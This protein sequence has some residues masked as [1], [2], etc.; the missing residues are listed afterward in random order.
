MNKNEPIMAASVLGAVLSL[1]V[2][3]WPQLV[4]F[5]VIFAICAS[6][7]STPFDA[8]EVRAAAEALALENVYILRD[9]VSGRWSAFE[10]GKAAALTSRS[11][12]DGVVL[13][14]LDIL[15][16]R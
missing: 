1:L 15:S 5:A 16:R 14:A 10:A 4:L 13:N 6:R 8:D 7:S 2:M 12:Y 9:P 3:S 11:S